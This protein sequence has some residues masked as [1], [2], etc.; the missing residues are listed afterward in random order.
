MGRL[1]QNFQ[2]ENFEYR[3][4]SLE[5]SCPKLELDL[6]KDEVATGSFS[7]H[8]SGHKPLEGWILTIGARLECL[9]SHFHENETEVGYRFDAT[10]L[11]EGEVI[12]GDI[13]V[14]SNQ[15]EYSLPYVASIRHNRIE[16][17]LGAI[18][19]LFHFANLAKENWKEAVEL[20]YSPGFRGIFQ[21]SDRQFYAAY[22]GFSH[23]DGNEQNVEQFLIEVHKKQAV[24]LTVEKEEVSVKYMGRAIEEE[25]PILRNGWGYT[26][27]RVETE[28]DF[29]EVSGNLLR[30]EDFIL[31]RC[32]LRLRIHEKGL[33]AGVNPGEVRLRTCNGTIRIP[34]TVKWLSEKRMVSGRGAR[35]KKKL[36]HKITKEYLDFRLQRTGR[37]AWL[38]SVLQDV[39]RLV[40]MGER[41]VAPR[42]YQAQLLLTEGKTGEVKW[43]LDHAETILDGSKE[44]TEVWCY[45]LYLTAL[46]GTDAAYV[47]EIRE[48]LRRAYRE[49][50]DNWRIAWLILYLEDGY[51]KSV[52]KKWLFLEE[53]FY[54]GAVS[55]VLYIEAL[56]LLKENTS[57]LMKLEGFELQILWF[58]AKYHALTRDIIGQLHYLVSRVKN[59]S[60][61]LYRILAAG[62][63]AFQD[64]ITLEAVC[65]L[66]IKGGRSGEEYFK[67]FELGVQEGLRITQLYEYYMM[68]IPF[69]CEERI[70]KM[71]LMYFA[72]QSSLE[73]RKNA[74]LY[75]KVWREREEQPELFQS[76]GAGIE[77][78]VVEQ[79]KLGHVNKDLAYLYKNILTPRMLTP[80]LGQKL[81]P[82]LFSHLITVNGADM[83]QVVLV[84]GGRKGELTF[85]IVHNEA[86]VPIYGADY[87][88]FLEDREG[89]RYAREELY[90][91]EKLMLPGKLVKDVL[92]YAS[93]NLD[94]ALYISEHGG[95]FSSLTSRNAGMM[96]NIVESEEVL[97]AIK[98][99]MSM[100]LLH[101]YFENDM[102]EQL[103]AFL[104]K[105]QDAGLN[106]RERSDVIRYMIVREMYD[107]ALAWVKK[108]GFDGLEP[109]VVVRLCSR[110]LSREEVREDS[111]LTQVIY[112]AYKKGKYDETILKYLVD[113]FEG[114]IK[115]M[116]D[117]WKSAR[118]FLVEV[119]PICEKMIEQMLFTGSYIAERM[120]VYSDYVKGPAD[121]NIEN[122]FLERCSYEYF[123]K[124]RLV[125]DELWGEIFRLY[126]REGKIHRICQLAYLKYYAAEKEQRNMETDVLAGKFLEE[127]LAE[128]IYFSFFPEYQN[129][130]PDLAGYVDRT[131]LEYQTDPANKVVLHYMI[132]REGEKDARYQQEVMHNMYAGI[133]SK[134]FVLFFGE[135]L[136]YY[137]TE[138]VDR[139]EQLTESGSIRKSDIAGEVTESR[140]GI[141]NDI[142]IAKTLRDYNTF[143]QL[144]EEYYEKKYLTEKLFTL[145]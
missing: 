55:P 13:T 89:I 145:I 68:S 90:M 72:Y 42:L 91:M 24:V 129:I 5:F 125:E 54:R 37:E 56:G 140:F 71:V 126:G 100:K 3:K 38:D 31:D 17:S 33:H 11:G 25:L 6:K 95:S 58:A 23:L 85:P 143:D 134:S 99:E 27:V 109:K 80:E 29:L 75:A 36:L 40:L 122:A 16:S 39:D 131:V 103:D 44:K 114:P 136:Q 45:Y 1:A 121:V 48:E 117:I 108:T 46:C 30:E 83:T 98:R 26:N 50:P 35:E 66:L 32:V 128:N 7:I 53:Q 102:E 76:Y 133:F 86:L 110:I 138:E 113:N 106:V 43:V 124:N 10:G 63:E 142:T 78:F 141:I 96:S 120:E 107:S 127:L 61:L 94:F 41:E 137:I 60:G 9:T 4:G 8:G 130:L 51:G 34:V 93:E 65:T 79:L 112:Y 64:R 81:I 19:N 12:K 70:P 57:L 49:N 28:G 22:R 105:M 18:K 82:V 118:E 101:F 135:C 111:E 132:E 52:Q 2:L 69:E 59:F 97:P 116:R 139:R 77:R 119:F 74:M 87:K 92:P 104:L 62:Y 67:W 20:F 21:G 15:G 73:Y 84:Y 123:V 144:T 47:E 14:I 115:E 88:L